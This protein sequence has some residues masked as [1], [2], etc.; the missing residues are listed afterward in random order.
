MM[1]QRKGMGNEAFPIWN[2]QAEFIS[3][4]ENRAFL[5][6]AGTHLFNLQYNKKSL[7]PLVQTFFKRLARLVFFTVPAVC[8][9][10]FSGQADSFQ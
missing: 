9:Y 8:A 2:P 5:A 1:K 3:A 4:E 6:C 7:Y 10:F